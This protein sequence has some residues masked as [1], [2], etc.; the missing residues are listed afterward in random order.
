MIINIS[1]DKFKISVTAF[2]FSLFSLN[3]FGQN[4]VP[5]PGFESFDV[6][7]TGFSE[8]TGYVSNWVDPTAANPDYMNACANPLPAGVPQNGVGYQQT[9][10]GDGYAGAY[11]DGGG[12]YTEYIQVQLTSPMIAGQTYGFEMYVVLHNKSEYATDDIGA[13]FSVAAP[14]SAGTGYFSG[15]PLPQ[16]VNPPGNVIT[17]TLNW[18]LISGTYT[19]TGGEEYLTIGHFKPDSLT[20]FIQL[21]YGNLGPY[22]YMDD[23]SVT[24]QSATS[25]N[26]SDTSVCEKFCVNFFDQS[27]N[28]P[29]SWVWSFPGG[30]P[31]TSTDQNP[32]NICYQNPGTY[33]V[34]LI[35]SNASGSDTLLLS[36]YITVNPTPPI[37]TITQNGLVLTSS[38]A[39]TYQWQFNTVDIPGATDQ[40]YTVTQ[41]GAYTVIVGD[42]NGCINSAGMDIVISGLET[43]DNDSNFFIY[44]S[45][46]SN[47]FVIEWPGSPANEKL[48]LTLVN[49]LGQKF[50][51]SEELTYINWTKKLDLTNLPPGIY[52][53]NL[54]MLTVDRSVK[55]FKN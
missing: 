28:N 38:T 14:T 27:T 39:S 7:P 30:T 37:P 8:F 36:S 1:S 18:Q 5:N 41:S 48:E 49:L 3:V 45:A 12:F 17:D 21:P 6:C 9:H 54:H 46:T 4:L 16:I 20:T 35:S 50:Y 55:I 44:Q 13:Y 32:T 10:G 11:F 40:S 22:Y 51:A 47:E 24:S 29:T 23:I 31:A 26:A 19:A 2:C 53:V 25:F 42:T 34:T 15:N 52:F 33:D 43:P